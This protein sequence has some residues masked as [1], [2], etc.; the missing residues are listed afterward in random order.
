MVAAGSLFLLCL[1]ASSHPCRHGSTG[2]VRRHP[3]PL[4]GGMAST[5]SL[6]MIPDQDEKIRSKAGRECDGK[7][8]SSC[9]N[10]SRSTRGIAMFLIRTKR[11]ET[12]LVHGWQPNGNSNDG[13][14]RLMLPKASE[15]RWLCMGPNGPGECG[16]GGNIFLFERVPETRGAS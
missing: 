6:S 4:W 5:S 15:E 12:T 10:S 14:A 7:K 3:T 2:D 1:T 11:T 13:K 16:M 8:G 9:C